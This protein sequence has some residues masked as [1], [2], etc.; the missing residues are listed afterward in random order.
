M[1]FNKFVGNPILVKGIGGTWDDETIQKVSMIY[2]NHIWYM[3]YSGYDGSKSRIGLATSKDGIA[4]T[5][6]PGNPVLDVGAAGTWDVTRAY[7]PHVIYRN[8]IWYMYYSGYD[9]AKVRIG[10]ATSKDGIAWTKYPGNPVLDVGAGIV[11]D[12]VFSYSPSLIYR[13]HIWYMYYSGYYGGFIRVGLATSKDG[14]AWTKYSGNP[15]LDVGAG[16]TWDDKYAYHTRVIYRNHIWYMYYTG[17][18]SITERVGLATSKDGIAWTKYPG[19]PILNVGAG[20]TWDS[21]DVGHGDLIY[22]NHKWYM[23]YDGSGAAG[24]AIGLASS[25]TGV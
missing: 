6:Y 18:D 7:I 22:R 23:Y 15:I 13:N 9:G 20:G 16:G 4:W 10:L 11:W 12:S 8:H 25:L 19:N 1:G 14:I 24:L 17:Y 2:R 3:Y 5:K 21:D